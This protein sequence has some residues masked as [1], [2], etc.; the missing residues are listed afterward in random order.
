M[1][2]SVSDNFKT[3]KTDAQIREERKQE[4]LNKVDFL[5]GYF[6]ENPHRFATYF[7]NLN[8]KPFQEILICEMMRNNFFNYNASRSQGKTYLTSIYCVIRC[9]LYPGTRICVA[10]ATLKQALAVLKKIT[11]DLCLQHGYGSI[12]LKNEIEK[13]QMNGN[14]PNILFK[15]GSIIYAVAANKN[16]RS[17][18]ANI[19]IC[20][21]FVQMNKDVIDRV[22]VPFLNTPRQPGYLNKAEYADLQEDSKQFY[23]T[24]AWYKSSWSYLQVK[25]YIKLMILGKKKYF[26]VSLP[27]QLSIKENLLKRSTVEAVMDKSDFNPVSFAME[28]ECI[29]F[30]SNGD[31]FFSYDDISK[32]RNLHKPLPPIE[33]ILNNKNIDVSVPK[34]RERRILSVD[35]A[36][37]VSTKRKKNDATA[38]IINNCIPTNGNRY[39]A[40]IVYAKNI[41]GWTT[42]RVGVEIMR[43]YYKYKC[44]DIVVD[45]AG[46]GLGVFD[47]IIKPQVD[48]ETGEIY[49]ALSC[50]NDKDMALRCMIPEAEKVIWSVKA[51]NKFNDLIA[52]S[53]REGFKQGQINLL[54][55]E[56]E[57]DDYLRENIKGYENKSDLEQLEYKH[58]Y[59][60][61]T[62]LV[63]ELINL[64][65]NLE[66]QYIKIKER[67]GMRKDR[68]SSLAYNFWVMKQYELKLSNDYREEQDEILFRFRKPSLGQSYI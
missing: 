12:L 35:V 26:S 24:S 53:L 47:T 55:N 65:H 29:W 25:D 45:T 67:P 33:D 8:L 19:L 32:R 37:M 40:N 1:E 51:N 9:I 23:L 6:R 42:D 52:T 48:P 49:P 10:S 59:I 16:A 5:A 13:T 15:N 11:E 68:Y 20:D 57:C 66:G 7:L 14:D 44:T 34:Y 17:K 30:G 18:R 54:V 4:F 56:Y 46:Q 3:V 2:E 28:Y 58:Q 62:L 41:E 38:I 64:Q 43:Y 61:T 22:L 60:E 36:L 63:N 21:E 31:E 39:V 27:Y 50:I